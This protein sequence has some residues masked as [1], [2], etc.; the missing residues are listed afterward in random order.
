[1][2]FVTLFDRNYLSRAIALYNSLAKNCAANF[3][4]YVLALDDYVEDFFASHR[5]ENIVVETLA[6]IKS[7]YPVLEKLQQ[8]RTRS[9][10]IWT[11]SAFSIQYVIKKYSLDSCTYLDADTYFYSDP[12]ILLNEVG[13]KSVLITPHNYTPRYDQSYTSGR[14]CVQFVY[15]KN[16]DAGNEVL[17]WWRKSC[18]EC[19][20]CVP[21]DGKFGDQKYLDDWLSRFS[22]KV[23]EC[24]NVGAGVAPWNVQKFDARESEDALYVTDK[25]TKITSQVIFYHFHS[26]KAYLVSGQKKWHLGGYEISNDAIEI[27]Y[28]KYIYQLNSIESENSMQASQLQK[29]E[30]PVMENR[31]SIF[32][33]ALK[34][35]IKMF[36]KSFMIWRTI[37][38][39]SSEQSKAQ[40]ML[41]D[42]IKF[43]G[44]I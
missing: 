32:I 28:E 18:E 24:S 34:Q 29:L 11:L 16:D 35:S 30:F 40:N 2:N 44:K 20:C 10:F 12:Q 21:T 27:F 13:D 17:E 26:L 4:L 6:G 8:Q 15:F 39:I 37:K 41:L 9:E 42:D 5:Y 19:C 38:Q 22:G 43:I 33:S 1:M 3:C 31:F 36:V 7:A 14:Y 25:I 23:K